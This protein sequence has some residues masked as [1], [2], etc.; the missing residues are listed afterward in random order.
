MKRKGYLI[1]EIISFS[2]LCEAAYKAFK[3]KWHTAE[4]QKFQRN[5]TEC[6]ATLQKHL[7]SGYIEVGKYNEFVIYEPK[8][9]LICAASLSQR[10]LHHAIMNVCHDLFD[11]FQIFDSYASR[12]DK[13]SHRAI[14]RLKDKMRVYEFYVKLDIRKY[15]D[16]ISHDILKMKLN[17]LFKDK[18]LLN[19]FNIII[20]SYGDDKGLPIGNLTS[21][22]FANHYLSF[23]DHYMKEKIGCPVYIRYMDDVI[24]LGKDKETVNF[25]KRRYV[26]FVKKELQLDVKPPIIGKVKDGILFLG[27]R[28]YRNYILMSGKGK[29]RI[30]KNL[31]KINRLY[32]ESIISEKEY[33]ERLTACMAY[34]S[35]AVFKSYI[36]NFLRL[37]VI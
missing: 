3:G 13:G 19:L 29:R 30:R 18:K 31:L 20:D 11:R 26:D 7:Y 35:F 25:Y 21:Q 34:A 12:P 8:K 9:R 2:N 10:V 16:S 4:V 6:I 37:N 15:F 23:A 14:R 1:D 33:S 5:F 28:I 32:E 17:R 27:Y 36:R 22:Y 24:M